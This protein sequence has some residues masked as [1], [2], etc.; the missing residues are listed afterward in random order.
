[1]VSEVSVHGWW[2]H[3]FG[4]EVRQNQ[5]GGSTWEIRDTHFMEAR[6][7]RGREKE[8][9]REI[10]RERERDRERERERERKGPGTGYTIQSHILQPSST[11]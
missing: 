8:R 10:E 4:P 7:Q 3:F 1:M 6:K 5:H 9:E 11:S 2:Y